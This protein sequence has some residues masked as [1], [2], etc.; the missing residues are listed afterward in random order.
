[1]AQR[2][3]ALGLV[4]AIGLGVRALRP[5]EDLPFFVWKYLGS[6]LWATALYL[7]MAIVAPRLGPARTAAF[8]ALIAIAVEFSRLLGFGWLDAF[9]AT[10][11]GRL[12]IGKVFALSNLVA[13]AAG[14]ALGL[15]LD[16]AFR[17][18]AK[19]S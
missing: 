19:D 13:Y 17:R 7:A 2:L 10:L 6:A 4:I 11:T 16:A 14:I 9:R 18:R 15:A 12:L 3:L 8:A 1:M 5:G